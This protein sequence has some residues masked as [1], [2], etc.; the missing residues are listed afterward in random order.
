MT[1]P[2]PPPPPPPPAAPTVHT[3]PSASTLPINVSH[4]TDDWERI[5]TPSAAGW[6]PQGM[7]F[8]PTPPSEWRE[9]EHHDIHTPSDQGAMSSWQNLASLSQLPWLGTGQVPEPGS[10]FQDGSV[11][12]VGAFCDPYNPR[13]L[14]S[15]SQMTPTQVL[16]GDNRSVLNPGY[17]PPVGTPNLQ[18][19]GMCS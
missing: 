2:P 5:T 17:T 19:F 6:P 14:A 9:A 12:S 8:Q 16:P 15:L 13:S 1:H 10:R 18:N 4:N 3:I 7:T 11:H